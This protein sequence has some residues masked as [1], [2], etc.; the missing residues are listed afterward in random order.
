[1]TD[2]LISPETAKL[3]KEKRFNEYCQYSYYDE[4]N[5]DNEEDVNNTI[6]SKREDKSYCTAPTQSLLQK[7][8]RE[9]HKIFVIVDYYGKDQFMLSILN[10]KGNDIL[11]DLNVDNL[12]YEQ[13]L[14][15][16]LIEALKFIK[17]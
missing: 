11:S 14:E 6:L 7:W 10:C 12:N 13:A 15:A 17:S 9:V 4:F 3:A 8:L 2:Q 5:L 1:M 16:G